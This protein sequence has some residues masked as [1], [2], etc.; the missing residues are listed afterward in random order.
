[1]ER[2]REQDH[3]AFY[4]WE[5]RHDFEFDS[6]KDDKNI[7][8]CYTLCVGR[9]CFI[10]SEKFHLKSEQAPSKPAQECETH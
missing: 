3:A 6:V 5:Y 10:Y 2:R 9:K 7:S 4:V 1:M 8:V